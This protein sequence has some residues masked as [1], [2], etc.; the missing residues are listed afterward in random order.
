MKNKYNTLKLKK[1]VAQLEKCNYECVGGSLEKNVAFIAL[2]KMVDNENV[3]SFETEYQLKIF[4]EIQ[5]D[6]FDENGKRYE[7]TRLYNNEAEQMLKLINQLESEI[8][9]PEQS[10]QGYNDKNICCVCH[11]NY[12]DSDDGFDTCKDCMSNI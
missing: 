8:N 11:K 9:S 7:G 2:K 4:R 12:V 6:L 10:A 3:I 1:I 5:K